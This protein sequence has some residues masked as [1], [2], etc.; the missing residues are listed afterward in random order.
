MYRW[1]YTAT[2]NSTK[3]SLEI[4]LGFEKRKIYGPNVYSYLIVG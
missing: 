3:Y 1:K 2:E 4:I